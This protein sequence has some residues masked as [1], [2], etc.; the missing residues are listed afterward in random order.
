MNIFLKC[1]ALCGII[2][3][4]YFHEGEKFALKPKDVCKFKTISDAQVAPD[5]NWVLYVVSDVDTVNDKRISNVFMVNW[6]GGA[7]VQLTYGEEGASCPRWSPDGKS[8][9]FLSSRKSGDKVKGRQ[10]WILNRIG[11]EA[12]PLTKVKGDLSSFE[13]SPDSKRLLLEM[14]DNKNEDDSKR[15]NPLP[16]VINRYHFKQDVQGYLTDKHTHLYLFDIASEKLDTLTKGNYDEQNAVWSP[17]GAQIAFESNRTNN[18]DLNSNIDIFLIDSK[19]GAKIKQFT[20]WN[21]SDR[22][23]VW[24]PDGKRLA[25]LR[26]TSSENYLM[27]DQSILVM[28]AVSDQKPVLLTESLDRPVE[29]PVWAKDGKSINVLITDDRQQYPANILIANKRLVKILG[30]NRAFMD[31]KLHPS[32]GMLSLMSD[33]KL[34]AEL[35]AVEGRKL[36]RITFVNDDLVKGFNLADVEGFTSTSKDGMKVS[37]ILYRPANT[38]LEKKLPLILFI[39][40]GPVGQDSYA[41]D[42]TRQ[43]LAANGFAV[44]AVNYRGSNGRGLNYTKA[45]YGNWGQL[46]VADLLGAVDYLIAR[47]VADPER[48]GI[49]GWSYGGILTDYTI[50]TTTRFKAAASGAGSAMQLSL[51]GVDQYILQWSNEIGA[52]WKNLDKYLELSYPFLKADRI[53]TPT[54]FMAGEKDFN[55]PAVGSEQMYQALKSLNIP[56]ELII[57]PGQ[58]HGISVPSYQVDRLERYN[59]WFSKY[60]K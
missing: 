50:A 30:G 56:T 11:G 16:L 2:F 26:S 5:G 7:P 13:W 22:N 49:G 33:P 20:H 14:A 45:I 53:K 37:G 27:Y 15:K 43:M 47:G 31:L 36:R 60:L 57:Y 51:Y 10:V 3:N 54:L 44:A 25:W 21:G 23:P 9:A 34:P 58:F 42:L 8:L 18:P 46:E 48:L 40:G 17:D 24:S 4:S 29:S 38:P 52:P 6:K 59:A 12:R 1:T 19:A 41:F 35:F 32:G 39:H 28:A 55:V